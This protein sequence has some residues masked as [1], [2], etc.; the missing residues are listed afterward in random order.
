VLHSVVH[1]SC[2]RIAAAAADDH[3]RSLADAD[4]TRTAWSRLLAALLGRGP[5]ERSVRTIKHHNE[6]WMFKGRDAG[7]AEVSGV[8]GVGSLFIART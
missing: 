1:R 4:Q 2:S 7:E 3:L 8:S 6:I 5:S